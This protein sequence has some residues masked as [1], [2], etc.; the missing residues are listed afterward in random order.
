MGPYDLLISGALL[1]SAH[2]QSVFAYDNSRYDNVGLFCSLNYA[3]QQ[4][5]HISEL[6]GCCV[7]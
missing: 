5:A 6:L 2:A 3:F 7:S 4:V 1:L